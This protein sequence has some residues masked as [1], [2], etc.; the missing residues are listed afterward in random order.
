VLRTSIRHTVLYALQWEMRDRIREGNDIVVII[1]EALNDT[2]GMTALS[3]YLGMAKDLGIPFYLVNIVC[4]KEEHL[5]RFVRRW[6]QGGGRATLSRFWDKNLINE[7]SIRARVNIET[8]SSMVFMRGR[9]DTTGREA[10]DSAMEILRWMNG[11]ASAVTPLDG[12]MV[13]LGSN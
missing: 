1:A 7:A 2:G 5:T 4:E 9:L 13:V 3:E 10:R 11:G 6:P 12:P 8:L